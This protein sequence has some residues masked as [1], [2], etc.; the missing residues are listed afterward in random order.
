[1]KLR[2]TSFPLVAQ[3]FEVE[4]FEAIVTVVSVG[5]LPSNRTLL[6]SSTEVSAVPTFPAESLKATLKV[7]APSVSLEFAVYSAVQVFPVVFA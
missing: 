2:V 6:E 7:T 1:M 4:L 3:L 5:R